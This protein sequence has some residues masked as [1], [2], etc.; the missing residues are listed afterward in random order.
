MKLGICHCQHFAFIYE[1]VSTVPMAIEFLFICFLIPIGIIQNYQF[2]KKLK[3]EKRN[4]PLGR[5]GNV[6]EP[7]MSWFCCL[8]MIGFPYRLIFRWVL[9]NEVVP[10]DMIPEWLCVLL[11]LIDRSIS[12]CAA[13]NSL[14]V[15]LIRYVYI[16][17]DHKANQWEFDKVGT[18]FKIA[19]IA[20]PIGMEITHSII[21]SFG[22]TPL[23]H[24]S[25]K[26]GAETLDGCADIL[27]AANVT[28]ASSHQ[29]V[30]NASSGLTPIIRIIFQILSYFYVII[31]VA[32][33]LNLIEAVLYCQ[34]FSN[35]K[36]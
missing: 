11:T 34:I 26:I 1:P 7:I 3:I 9:A 16:V 30:V 22:E 13:Y 17:H 28:Y 24:E 15:A 18:W 21:Y 35:I 27:P 6:I 2:R 29:T 12:F 36:R 19:S 31:S 20:F 10:F 33:A 4:R 14:F 8:Q 25:L 23:S 5:K 32:V